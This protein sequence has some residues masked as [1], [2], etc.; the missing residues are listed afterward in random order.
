MHLPQMDCINKVNHVPKK[1]DLRLGKT[2]NTVKVSTGDTKLY[3]FS[4]SD[5]VNL[6]EYNKKFI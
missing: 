2:A 6:D 5:N 3:N 1:K 4:E